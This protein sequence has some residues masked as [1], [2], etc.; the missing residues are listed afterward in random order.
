MDISFQ[1]AARISSHG[2]RSDGAMAPAPVLSPVP[3]ILEA[4]HVIVLGAS[5]MDAAFGGGQTLRPEMQTYAQ[6]A[7]FTGTL[8]A[9]SQSGEQVVHTRTRLAGVQTEPGIAATTG[10]NLYL[11]HTGGNNVS[12]SRPWPGGETGFAA[13]YDGLMQDITATDAVVPM[14]LTKRLYTSAPQV[15]HGDPASEANGSRPYNENIIYPA[16]DQYAPA[17]R[18]AGQA[19]FVNPYELADRYPQVLSSDGVHGYGAALGRYVLARVAARAR[20]LPEG[21]SRAGR[22]FLYSPQRGN[23]NEMTIGP[24]NRFI[25]LATGSFQNNPLLCG[26]VDTDGLFDPFIEA[27]TTDVFQNSS[28]NA[29][30]GTYVRLADARFHDPEIVNTGLYVQGTKVYELTFAHL[31]PGDTVRVTAAGVR[32]AGG[33]GR[34]GLVSLST[35]EAL[36]LDASNVA[37]SNQVSFAPVPVPADGRLTLSLAV[38]P[39]SQYGYLHG[40]LLE[41]L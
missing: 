39:G 5:I 4:P 3:G 10:Q 34:R 24:I 35:G 7:G 38:A 26:A 25:S 14:P 11:V 40:V 23:P 18:P 20:G 29:G 17:W 27:L 31:T 1:N 19:P 16:I 15:I 41:F 30:T 32:N 21:Q 2:R 12:G 36:E 37:A 6:A 22:A 13:E 8:H 28:N 33:T 9:R